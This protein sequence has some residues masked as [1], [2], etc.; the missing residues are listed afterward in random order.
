MTNLFG[1]LQSLSGIAKAR[2]DEPSRKLFVGYIPNNVLSFTEQELA[3]HVKMVEQLKDENAVVAELL[4]KATRFHVG[5]IRGSRIEVCWRGPDRW[6]ICDGTSVLNDNGDWEHEP[7]PS[8]R[9]DDFL[10]RTRFP[11]EEAMILAEELC[12]E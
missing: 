2:G 3:D 6:A 7:L 8:S 11:F 9:S 1:L 4:L 10:E 12:Q 5:T